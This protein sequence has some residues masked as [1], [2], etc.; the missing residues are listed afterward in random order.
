MPLGWLFFLS[1][2]I[3]NS[4]I[5]LWKTQCLVT[6][7]N[8]LM[9]WNVIWVILQTYVRLS[10]VYLRF[11]T[12]RESFRIS[13]IFYRSLE[14]KLNDSESWNIKLTKNLKNFIS[15]QI[16]SSRKNI[17]RIPIWHMTV[18]Q[19]IL[20]ALFSYSVFLIVSKNAS[21]QDIYCISKIIICR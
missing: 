6:W 8:C 5:C 16:Y 7:L 10:T 11:Y 14:Q 9:E 12:T 21:I 18:E 19:K 3:F 4:V 15:H 2:S 17:I 1:N 13:I 20:L